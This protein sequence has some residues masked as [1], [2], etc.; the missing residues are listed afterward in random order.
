MN[1]EATIDGQTVTFRADF[2]GHWPSHIT[3][4]DLDYSRA[5][6]KFAEELQK[7]D[8]AE[9]A[10]QFWSVNDK[11]IV[12]GV[13]YRNLKIEVSFYAATH[14]NIEPRLFITADRHVEL[15]D[16]NFSKLLGQKL[17]DA[18]RQKLR[19]NHGQFFIETAQSVV[20]DLRQQ[21]RQRFI[22]KTLEKIDETRA[23]LDQ[24]SALCGEEKAAS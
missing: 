23:T 8:A 3:G 22:D 17:T 21:C 18:A 24:I 5:P 10:V 19:E 14:A 20:A 9:N 13:E 16:P 12:N 2:D 1:I 15:G 4:Q 11:V 7:L 6:R